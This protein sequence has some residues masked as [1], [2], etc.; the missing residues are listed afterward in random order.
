M[1]NIPRST[2]YYKNKTV[3]RNKEIQE[4]DLKDQLE[5]II[6]E[7]PGYGSRRVTEQLKRDGWHINRKRVQRIMRK[8][9][10]LCV[11]KR[12]KIWTANAKHNHRRYP[13]LIRN[14]SINNINQLWVVDITYIRVLRG[15]IFL[16]IVLD[17]HSRK[18]I[19]YAIANHLKTSLP[20]A[21]LMMAIAKRSPPLGCIHHSDQGLQY[22]SIDYTSILTEHGFKISMSRA[23]NPYDNAIAESFFKTLKNE[24]VYLWR[25]ESIDDAL[26][27]IPFFIQEVY[28]KKRLHSSLDYLTPIEFEDN[29]NINLEFSLAA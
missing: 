25:Y 6:C 1:L 3:N 8:N 7:F 28:N 12:K 10:L 24:E 27:R 13:N 21:A 16:A 23:G 22:A 15:F 17:A 20:L 26:K 29:I 18:V 14:I 11:V 4:A 19:G 9:E 2:F 5:R